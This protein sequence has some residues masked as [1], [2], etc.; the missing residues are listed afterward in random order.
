MNILLT[1]V[2]L[3]ILTVLISLTLNHY[4]EDDKKSKNQHI[5][6]QQ[7]HVMFPGH[8]ALAFLRQCFAYDGLLLAET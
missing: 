7:I 6:K 1:L 2:V 4:Y 8:F 5:I 3:L